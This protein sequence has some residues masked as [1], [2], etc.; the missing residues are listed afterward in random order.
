[1]GAPPANQAGDG[2]NPQAA[3][4]AIF[5]SV[6][7]EI[8]SAGENRLLRSVQLWYTALRCHTIS[9]KACGDTHGPWSSQLQRAFSLLH[10]ASIRIILRMEQV[11]CRFLQNQLPDER[12]QRDLPS[13]PV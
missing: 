11:T 8:G 5:L 6:F 4:L 12:P 3:A 2:R 10:H 7:K 13:T 9:L 1:M